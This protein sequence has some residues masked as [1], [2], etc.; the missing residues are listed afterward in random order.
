MQ[1]GCGYFQPS[2]ISSL[3]PISTRARLW[4]RWTTKIATT[5]GICTVDDGEVEVGG[6]DPDLVEEISVEGVVKKATLSMSAKLGCEDDGGM[7]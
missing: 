2:S 3:H 1:A 7:D 5:M 6:G 4:R